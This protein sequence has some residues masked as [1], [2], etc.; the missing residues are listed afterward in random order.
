MS[1]ARRPGLTSVLRQSS[2]HAGLWMDRYLSEHAD[3]AKAK[4]LS[5][6][7]G[8]PT[9]EG[10]PAAFERW[11]AGLTGCT[12]FRATTQGRMVIGLGA[13]GVVEA[14]IRLDRTWG[15]P[16]LPGSALKG[17]A[18]AA[19]HQ[20]TEEKNPRW[21]KGG[22]G[23][24]HAALFGTSDG[25]GL[26]EFLDAWWVPGDKLPFELDVITVHHQ[27]YYQGSEAPDGTESPVP[28]SF[29]SVAGASFLVALQPRPGVDARWVDAA[30]S[31]LKQ[32][33]ARLGI[34]AKTSSGYG[35][36]GVGGG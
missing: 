1:A 17:L 25:S 14:G 19:A 10:Y 11:M 13:K 22:K 18:A 36:L 20:L 24:L 30:A 12:T 28:N 31:L 5:G 26:V 6:L 8:M 27:R 29:L 33:L 16:V 3:G 9:P 7:V 35:R 2:T 4:H 21:K 32:G 15:V 34:G 23:D